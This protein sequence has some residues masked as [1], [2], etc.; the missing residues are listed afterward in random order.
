[1]LDLSGGSRDGERRQRQTSPCVKAVRRFGLPRD[2]D[3]LAEGLLTTP[4]SV[5]DS[6]RGQ[7]MGCRS[8]GRMMKGSV[9]VP[10]R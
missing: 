6:R 8:I 2:C 3:V 10:R 1:M 5:K 4:V 9:V 7:W